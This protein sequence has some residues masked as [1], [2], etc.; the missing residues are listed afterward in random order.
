MKAAAS[1]SVRDDELP[2]PDMKGRWFCVG[3][4]VGVG[5]RRAEGWGSVVGVGMGIVV[6][7]GDGCMWTRAAFSRALRVCKRGI[8]PLKPQTPDPHT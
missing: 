6:G 8:P 2:P 7:I 4:C 1:I 5:P 3:G